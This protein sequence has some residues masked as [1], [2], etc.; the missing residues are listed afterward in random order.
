MLETTILSQYFPTQLM[1]QS[2]SVIGLPICTIMSVELDHR[3]IKVCVLNK[4]LI[5]N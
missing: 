2:H 4:C 3:K 1:Y 5:E